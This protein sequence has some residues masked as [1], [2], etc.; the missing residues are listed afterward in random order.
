MTGRAGAGAL[1]PLDGSP[2]AQLDSDR[3]SSS[4][5]HTGSPGPAATRAEHRPSIIDIHPF[6]P[7]FLVNAIIELGIISEIAAPDCLQLEI[8]LLCF[9]ETVTPLQTFLSSS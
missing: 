5:G 2:I 3:D 8:A 6:R 4:H 1:A 7:S 9:A